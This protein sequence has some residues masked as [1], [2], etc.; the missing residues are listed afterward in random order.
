MS[1]YLVRAIGGGGNVRAFAADT[2][3]LV[4]EA[5][6][7]HGTWP[8]VT[9]ALGRALTA[10]ALLSATLKDEAE[11]LTVRIAGD[12][13]AG[14]IICDADARG[15]VRGYVRNPHVDLPPRS[16]KLDVAG[17]V[18][19]GHMHVTR[20]LALEGMYTGTSELVSGEIAE[21]LT[22]YLAQSEQTPSA[23][24]LGVL[25][26]TDGAV[27]ASGG[28]LVQLLP[29]VTESE[30]EQLEV[31][32]RALG[33]VSRA[34]EQGLTPEELLG[35][36]LAG[37]EHRV[38][39]QRDVHFACRCSRDRALNSV[40]LVD[41]EGLESIIDADKGA[42]MTCHFCGEVYRFTEAELLATRSRG[43]DEVH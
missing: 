12:G 18:G 1:D 36:I 38:L 32:L 31:N 34:V 25:V 21:D 8:T 40:M 17:A 10:T 13:P 33:P 26:G 20:Q 23:V 41:P 22:Y 37:I 29:A 11:S 16:G 15:G 19:A 9:A 5:R 35:T 27:I 7:R 24:A 6:R 43:S 42:E 28:Y 4:N 39:E 30:R 2:T 3:A 14:G